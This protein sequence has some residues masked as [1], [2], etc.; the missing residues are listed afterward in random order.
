M[1]FSVHTGAPQQGGDPSIAITAVLSGECDD[2]GRQSR[3]ITGHRRKLALCGSVLAK[4]PTRKALGGTMLGNDMIHT[5]AVRLTLNFLRLGA[6]DALKT[7][8]SLA[9]TIN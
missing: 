4:N 7:G 6:D 9:L 1:R 2:V 3:F 8:E 5:G